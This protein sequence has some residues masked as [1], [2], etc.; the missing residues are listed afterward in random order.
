MPIIVFNPLRER[1][2]E[3]FADPQNVMEMATRRSTPIASTYYQ[4]RAGGDA[5]ALK[6]IA[7]A[8][9]QLEEEQGNVLDHAF[10]AQ[11]TQ[12][13]PPSPMTSTP[14]AG[15]TSNRSLA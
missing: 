3:R 10:I 13:S 14:P 4:V 15:R 9:L 5:A 11:H 7:K 1:A 6:G 8:L 12:D 2:L